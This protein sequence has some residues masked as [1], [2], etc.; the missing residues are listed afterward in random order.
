MQ[1][2]NSADEIFYFLESIFT[3]GFD[4]TQI[5]LALDVFLRDV[6][7]FEEKDLE[8]PTMKLF[9]RQLGRNLVTFN[10]EKNYVKTA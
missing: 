7:Q 1:E 4:E 3:E 6:H 2:F 9:I 5:S 8:S 10:D